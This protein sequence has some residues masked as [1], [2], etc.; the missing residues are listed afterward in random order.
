MASYKRVDPPGEVEL[1]PATDAAYEDEDEEEEEEEEEDV[2]NE[3][4]KALSRLDRDRPCSTQVKLFV[5]LVVCFFVLLAGVW[6]VFHRR[7]EHSSKHFACDYDWHANASWSKDCVALPG[8][9]FGVHVPRERNEWDE[10]FR[11][12]IRALMGILRECEPG[13]KYYA[14]DIDRDDGVHSSLLYMCNFTLDQ[15]ETAHDV[16]ASSD[17]KVPELTIDRLACTSSGKTSNLRLVFDHATQGSLAIVAEQVERQID[18]AANHTQPWGRAAFGPHHITVGVVDSASCDVPRLVARANAEIDWTIPIPE[19]AGFR[20]SQECIDALNDQ[21]FC[22]GATSNTV[23]ASASCAGADSSAPVWAAQLRQHLN[24]F[25]AEQQARREAA[26]RRRE[27]EAA[28][29]R[30]IEAANQAALQVAERKRAAAAEAALR[31]ER[32]AA[33]ER[34]LTGG[35]SWRSEGLRAV[36]LASHGDRVEL[37]GRALDELERSGAIEAGQAMTFELRLSGAVAAEADEDEDGYAFYAD[38]THCGVSGFSA[39]DGTIGL[40]PKTMLSLARGDADVAGRLE[41]GEARVSVRYVKLPAVRECRAMLRPLSTGFFRD[42]DDDVVQLDLKAALERELSRH[43]ALTQNDWIALDVDRGTVRLRVESLEPH[44]ALLVLNT[45]LEVEV[46]P[47]ESVDARQKKDEA[48]RLRREATRASR[49]ARVRTPPR[50]TEV[51][52]LLRYRDGHRVEWRFDEAMPSEALATL[53]DAH[54]TDDRLDLDAPDW[55][56]VASYPRRLFSRADLLAADKTIVDVVGSKSIALLV[57]AA[58]AD[59]DDALAVAGTSEEALWERAQTFADAEARR[60]QR[61]D[62][63][64]PASPASEPTAVASGAD[65]AAVFKDLVAAGVDRNEAARAA[66]RYSPQIRELDSMGLMRDARLAISFLDRYQ[67]RMLRVVNAISDAEGDVRDAVAEAMDVVVEEPP[68]T[69]TSSSATNPPQ[70]LIASIFQQLVKQGLPPNDAAARALVIAADSR[71]SQFAPQRA[72]LRSMGFDDLDS[73]TLDLLAN[74]R[75]R[76]DEV[77]ADLIRARDDAA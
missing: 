35:V 57:E 26:K 29:A 14:W 30:R 23:F 69:T 6:S 2:M 70:E 5:S 58:A 16:I 10:S 76:L 22:D 15:L 54:V 13:P 27:E 74:H 40:P 34:V 53:A 73:A 61:D 48:Q 60:K 45:D 62:G 36:A 68:P 24:V 18:E 7:A 77:V 65:K 56:L 38:A 49:L 12:R 1:A 63:D 51:R 32:L 31:Q 46:L 21:S 8:L 71:V 55:V 3:A 39:D 43:A 11:E 67:G 33:R 64:A 42:N 9:A 20:C 17:I 59:D 4:D 50:G 75:G 28:I 44:K 37:S 52:V 41:S 19:D 25:P 72:Q 47:S 66:Q